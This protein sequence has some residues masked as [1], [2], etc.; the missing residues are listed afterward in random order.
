MAKRELP[1]RTEQRKKVI[2]IKKQ[3]PTLSGDIEEKILSMYANDMT[4][5]LT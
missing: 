2:L 1:K 4:S 5:A 3:Q